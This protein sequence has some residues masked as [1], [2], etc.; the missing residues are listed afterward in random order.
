[1]NMWLRVFFKNK[2]NNLIFYILKY[3]KLLSTNAEF[4]S[5][6]PSATLLEIDYKTG[7]LV[8]LIGAKVGSQVGR[9]KLYGVEVG[10]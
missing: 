3:L 2:K 7:E 5:L 10:F 8:E 9:I 6:F 1:M 4:Q